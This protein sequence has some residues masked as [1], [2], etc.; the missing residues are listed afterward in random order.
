MEG[1]RTKGDISKGREI[2]MEGTRENEE[3][4]E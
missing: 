2:R 1:I 3:E 4:E